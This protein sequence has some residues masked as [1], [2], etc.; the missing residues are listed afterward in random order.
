MR[1]E[2]AAIGSY[3]AARFCPETGRI[4]S[5]LLTDASRS[6]S[7]ALLRRGLVVIDPAGGS[8]R[9]SL[10]ARLAMIAD[11]HRTETTVPTGYL[12][13]AAGARR[14]DKRGRL[15]YDR[16]S[17]ALCACGWRGAGADRE[18]AR[19]AARRHRVEFVTAVLREQF[20]TG[21]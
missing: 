7:R 18:E 16:S 15:M 9:L 17:F 5:G 8:V 1:R 4:R 3:P 2:L 14:S 13:D 20:G 12:E 21:A 11:E 19:S 6:T 10:R